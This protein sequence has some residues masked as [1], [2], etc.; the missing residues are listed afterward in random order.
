MNRESKNTIVWGT[1]T[2]MCG[3]NTYET[4]ANLVISQF[5]NIRMVNSENFGEQLNSIFKGR[6]TQL[7]TAFFVYF[8][9]C[10]YIE[11]T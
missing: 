10:T 2:A 4:T 1:V 9:I 11:E 8:F 6:W 5:V 7:S 3:W